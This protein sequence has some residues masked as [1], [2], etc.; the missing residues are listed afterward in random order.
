MGKT[1]VFGWFLFLLL[2]PAAQATG[3]E[4]TVKTIPNTHLSDRNSYVSNPDGIILPA[5]EQSINRALRLLED[6][7]GIEVAVVAVENIGGSDARQFATDLFQ[8]WGLG[9]EKED[10]GLLIQLITEASQ[11]SVVFETGYGLEGVLPDAICY[12]LQQQYMI[13]DLKTGNYSSGMRDG[14]LAVSQYLLASDYERGAMVGTDETG[15]IPL[16]MLFLFMFGVPLL[17]SLASV[18]AYKY[19]HRKRICP[20]CGQK[21]FSYVRRQTI[22]AA[23]YRAEGLA[24]DIYR[25]TNCGHTERKEHVLSRLHQSTAPI[26][27][28]GGG[29][30]F[31]RGGGF[32]GGFGG[33]SWGG[34]SSGGGGSI[35][36]F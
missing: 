24:V 20:N 22:T 13:G 4:Y 34:G 36:R 28:G 3:T 6:S 31:D 9:K 33:G 14:V 18:W 11:R 25:C 8:H 29:G 5:D 19:K 35:S 1:T 17:I 21:T 26:I 30:G 16:Y 10:N 23:T 12:R 7:L 32:G 2:L 27:I 15:D